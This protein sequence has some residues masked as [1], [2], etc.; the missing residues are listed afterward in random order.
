MSGDC[1]LRF[2]RE[3]ADQFKAAM[4]RALELHC[5]RMNAAGYPWLCATCAEEWPCP[6]R[7]EQAS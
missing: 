6:T 7:R 5:L 2:L 4:T 1:D 3:A